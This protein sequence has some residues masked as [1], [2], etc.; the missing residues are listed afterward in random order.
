MNYV[1]RN[2][3]SSFWKSHMTVVASMIY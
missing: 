2:T 3:K 1:F